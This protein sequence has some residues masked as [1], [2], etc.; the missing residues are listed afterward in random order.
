MITEDQL[1]QL[2]LQWFQD[3]G[4][5]YISGP[6]LAPEGGTPERADF[7]VVVLRGR[8]ATAVQRLNPKLPPTAVDEVVHVV[9]TPAHPS[10]A[11]NNH[12]FHRLLMDGVKVEFTNASGEKDAD[13]AQL[14]DFQNPANNDFLVVNQFTVTGTK[15]PRRPDIVVFVNGLPLGIIELK[16]S[17]GQETPT[18]WKAYKQLQTYKD[19][20]FRPPDLQRGRWW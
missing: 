14:I 6:D 18:I 8:L 2:A 5:T 19:E 17:G 7:R 11:R 12:A 4:W 13:H 15:K 20:I 3:T 16:K 9:T 1:E 10:L